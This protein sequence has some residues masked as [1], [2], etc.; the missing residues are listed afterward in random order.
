MGAEV[1]C[2]FSDARAAFAYADDIG[3]SVFPA[4]LGLCG[5]H[6]AA[7]RFT[8]VQIIET[9]PSSGG[10]KL[11]SR[12]SAFG[13][14]QWRKV[15]DRTLAAIGAPEGPGFASVTLLP[16]EPFDHRDEAADLPADL[17]ASQLK[18][19]A[20]GPVRLS[21]TFLGDE[22]LVRLELDLRRGLDLADDDLLDLATI[23]V[24]PALAIEAFAIA[25]V[26]P[27]GTGAPGVADFSTEPEDRPVSIVCGPALDGQERELLVG[28]ATTVDVRGGIE[29][30]EFRVPT[31]EVE[32]LRDDPDA[33]ADQD[34]APRV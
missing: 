26:R 5:V 10:H 11:R 18:G 13:D 6:D 29:R 8:V 27:V 25:A 2:R 12:T 19:V 30:L 17:P 14:A 32:R 7:E 22:V 15:V 1:V 20:P 4:A 33:L 9:S 24:G 23:V 16:G 28:S 34:R 21:V 3:R 31:S